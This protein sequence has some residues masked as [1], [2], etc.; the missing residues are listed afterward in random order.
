MSFARLLVF[1]SVCYESVWLVGH[2]Q[3][4]VDSCMPALIVTSLG[5]AEQP[6]QGASEA[7][8]LAA[9]NAQ[10]LQIWL[11][12]VGCVRRDATCHTVRAHPTL[13]ASMRH[14]FR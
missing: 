10:F 4:C 14:H 12:T 7:L 6:S 9:K 11:S 1:L 2:L 5:Q 3:S 8:T 13:G